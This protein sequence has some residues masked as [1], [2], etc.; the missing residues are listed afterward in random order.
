M[1][2]PQVRQEVQEAEEQRDENSHVHV[3]AVFQARALDK[4]HLA[5]DLLLHHRRDRHA[6]HAPRQHGADERA[7]DEVDGEGVLSQPEEV[8]AAQHVLER[9]RE[10]DGEADEVH[11]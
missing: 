3:P 7:V 8:F 2:R 5:L 4:R 10:E 11:A 9:G 1:R 6:V